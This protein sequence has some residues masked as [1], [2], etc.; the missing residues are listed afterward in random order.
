MH[1]FGASAVTG[2]AVVGSVDCDGPAFSWA[3]AADDQ[4]NEAGNTAEKNA[5]DS[6]FVFMCRPFKT[7]WV[8]I[9][10]STAPRLLESR[11]G[12]VAVVP[13]RNDARARGNRTVPKY[14]DRAPLR[15]PMQHRWELT[16]SA[17]PWVH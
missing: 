7:V 3:S 11:R 1:V 17:P 13:S 2:V 8:Y 10:R 9:D 15:V 16:E 14:G 12:P 6:A 5:R 4:T